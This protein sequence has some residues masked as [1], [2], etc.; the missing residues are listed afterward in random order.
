[1]FRLTSL[2]PER[3]WLLEMAPI[4]S[5][6]MSFARAAVDRDKQ[7]GS[8]LK[9]G[10]KTLSVRGKKAIAIDRQMRIVAGSVVVVG[11]V[12]AQFVHPY[13]IGLSAFVGAG[14]VFAGVTD[15]CPMMNMLAKMPWNQVGG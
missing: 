10:A 14:L 1:M 11:V 12:L 9:P 7:L 8:S 6:S 15:S 4:I 5:R 3:S 13:F 2:T